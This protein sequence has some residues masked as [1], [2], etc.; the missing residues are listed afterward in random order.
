[1]RCG[2][3]EN[4]TRFQPSHTSI[5]NKDWKASTRTQVES[6]SRAIQKKHR[7]I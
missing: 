1:V 6:I 5:I 2:N 3:V 4:A 7:A